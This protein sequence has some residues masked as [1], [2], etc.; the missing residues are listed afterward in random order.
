M[1]KRVKVAMNPNSISD[2]ETFKP[3]HQ[4]SFNRRVE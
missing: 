4:L 3:S 1:N 2:I